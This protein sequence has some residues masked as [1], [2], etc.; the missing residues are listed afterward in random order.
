MCVH[1]YACKQVREGGGRREEGGRERDILTA[2]W[3][4][5]IGQF[6]VQSTSKLDLLK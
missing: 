3:F 6:C 5:H 4:F 1:I 2:A